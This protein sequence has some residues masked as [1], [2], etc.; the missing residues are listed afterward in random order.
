MRK[1]CSGLSV[2]SKM[3]EIKSEQFLSIPIPKFN[4]QKL[5]D[6]VN[7]FYSGETSFSLKTLKNLDVKKTGLFQLD[8]ARKALKSHINNIIDLIINDVPFDPEKEL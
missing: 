6:V 1:Y 8:T 5:T 7:L 2:G 3:K 4:N